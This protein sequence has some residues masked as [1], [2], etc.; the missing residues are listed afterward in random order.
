MWLTVAVIILRVTRGFSTG[1]AF[2]PL[3]PIP[4]G[5]V[6]SASSG[7][8]QIF[9]V[10]GFGL[11]QTHP[12]HYRLEFRCRFR[13]LWFPGRL[14]RGLVRMSTSNMGKVQGGFGTTR[15]A[16]LWFSFTSGVGIAPSL[17]FIR[18]VIRLQWF[19][20]GGCSTTA[21]LTRGAALLEDFWWWQVDSGERVGK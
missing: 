3:C 5:R 16:M 7:W 21:G 10:R 9:E 17:L 8:T 2:V 13:S 19:R 14:G 1:S 18:G 12:F 20:T 4:P 15:A 11:V 6:V